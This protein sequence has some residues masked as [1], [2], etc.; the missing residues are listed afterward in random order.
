MDVSLVIPAYNE[1]KWIRQALASVLKVASGK[2]KEIIVV[3]NASTDRTAEFASSFPGVRVVR[4]SNKGTSFARLAGALA[5]SAPVIAFMDADE[6]MPAG[7]Y[8]RVSASFARDPQLAVLSGPYHYFGIAKWQNALIQLEWHLAYPLH[9]LM[10]TGV[11]GGNFAIRRTIFEK[12][13]GF[14][15]T[16]VFFG[17]D[18][19]IGRR[20]STF[21]EVRFSFKLF[22]NASSRRFK[23]AGLFHTLWLYSLN[24][25]RAAFEKQPRYTPTH[26]DFR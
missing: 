16:L 15:T 9:A 26:R 4:E 10:H 17:D 1:E 21:G 23:G 20:A 24:V 6:I 22:I 11:V 18:V 3:D 8:E 7:W 12:M 14:N 19:D 5:T 13:H 2:F 25:L